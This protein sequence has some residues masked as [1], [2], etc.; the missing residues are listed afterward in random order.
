MSAKSDRLFGTVGWMKKGCNI[1]IALVASWAIACTVVGV[2]QCV[3]VRRAWDQSVP[4]GCIDLTI[5]F[6]CQRATNLVTDLIL[7]VLPIKVV[8]GLNAS[9][10]KRLSLVF[11]FSMGFL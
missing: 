3:P 8:L 11:G 6:I 2:A 1:T 9:L 10:A 4:G 5:F 7:L